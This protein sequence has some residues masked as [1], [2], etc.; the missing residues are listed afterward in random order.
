MIKR[1]LVQLYILNLFIVQLGNNQKSLQNIK[2]ED[3]LQ[4][5]SSKIL[6]VMFI[7]VKI[8]LKEEHG[9]QPLERMVE[10]TGFMLETRN[11]LHQVQAI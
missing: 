4:L 3:Y 2:E 8:L 5:K 10:K 1:I 9:L 6:S 7:K 11:K